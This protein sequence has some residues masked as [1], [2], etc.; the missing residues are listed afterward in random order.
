MTSDDSFISHEL[1]PFIR[2]VGSYDD[3]EYIS[4]GKHQT[5]IKQFSVAIDSDITVLH[6]V[7]NICLVNN[8]AK[9]FVSLFVFKQYH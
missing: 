1:S 3:L 5:F 4:I 7:R 9:T 8:L 6:F 2:A